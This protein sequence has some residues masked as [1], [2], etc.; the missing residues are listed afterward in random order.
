MGKTHGTIGQVG[1]HRD[2][3]N[4]IEHD[5]A[6]EMQHELLFGL[7]R[8]KQM[9]GGR[10]EASVLKLLLQ[11]VQRQ[12]FRDQL[13]GVRVAQ[14][15]RMHPLI[16]AG[17]R[18]LPLEHGANIRDGDHPAPQRAEQRHRL[19]VQPA[20]GF[21]R[22]PAVD[23]GESGGIEAHRAWFSAFAALDAQRAAL[24]VEIPRTQR[25]GLRDSQTPTIEHRDQGGV[26]DARGCPP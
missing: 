17:L 2:V 9:T 11:C 20:L 5:W 14:A 10:G 18:R 1:T 4:A 25:Q 15:V 24:I 6:V 21:F 23:Q 13:R 22:P 7:S 16:D 3:L 26:S 12:S 19:R 8:L